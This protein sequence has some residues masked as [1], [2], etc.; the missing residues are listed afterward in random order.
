[1]GDKIS[2]QILFVVASG[3]NPDDFQVFPL[4]KLFYELKYGCATVAGAAKDI[5]NYYPSVPFACSRLE[6]DT[7]NYTE[8]IACAVSTILHLF[9]V[10]CRV[11]GVLT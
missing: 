5:R 2:Y 7:F 6:N 8:E 1:M 4:E 3:D 11:R 9:W 10:Y